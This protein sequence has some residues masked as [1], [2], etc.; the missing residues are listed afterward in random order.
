ML[1]WELHVEIYELAKIETELIQKFKE[2]FASC[3]GD[4]KS[5][6]ERLQN[7]KWQSTSGPAVYSLM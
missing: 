2:T 7:S 1:I 6:S 5:L 4:E 3:K